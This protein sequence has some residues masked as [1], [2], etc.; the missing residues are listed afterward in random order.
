MKSAI[1]QM[2]SFPRGAQEMAAARLAR[3][4]SS[5]LR[6]TFA[7]SGMSRAQLA[8]LLGSYEEQVSETLDGDGNLKIAALA[9]AMHALGWEVEINV[10]PLDLGAR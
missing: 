6:R 3:D 1:E 8:E 9:R 5:L 2:E 10:W 4:V 7:D